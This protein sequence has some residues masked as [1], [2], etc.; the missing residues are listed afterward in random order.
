MISNR[1]GLRFAVAGAAAKR[2]WPIATGLVSALAPESE[3][4]FTMFF[5]LT[6]ICA[7]RSRIA[8]SQQEMCART[9]VSFCAT[10]GGL[11]SNAIQSVTEYRTVGF[12]DAF[13]TA[14]AYSLSTWGLTKGKIVPGAINKGHGASY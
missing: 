1:R 3:L 6:K 11:T 14:K 7:P 9:D 2:A 8:T 12:L 10:R 13:G 5:I 4:A